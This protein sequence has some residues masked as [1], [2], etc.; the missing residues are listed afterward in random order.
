MRDLYK[1]GDDKAPDYTMCLS[2]SP[3]SKF[4]ATGSK[5]GEIKV[6]F[7]VVDHL[8]DLIVSDMDNLPKAC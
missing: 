5:N 3:D 4:L 2:F 1:S 6:S 7:S 8:F